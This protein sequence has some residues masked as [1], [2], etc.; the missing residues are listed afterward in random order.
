MPGTGLEHGHPITRSLGIFLND[1]GVGPIG[2]R[3]AGEDAHR[4]ARP[5]PAVEGAAG[6]NLP[7]P[8]QNHRRG[9]HI[10]GTHGVTVHRRHGG[11]RLGH[12]GADILRRHPA[13]RIG[14][15]HQFRRQRRKGGEDAAPG[16]GDWNHGGVP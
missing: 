9:R 6:L 12:A 14:Q 2:E 1:D 4:F 16:F 5:D 13:Q 11:G 8:A 7:D 3:S 10:L 15:R